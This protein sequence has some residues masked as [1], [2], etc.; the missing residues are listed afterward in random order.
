MYLFIHTLLL[1]FFSAYIS[2]ASFLLL[3]I[4]I[5]LYDCARINVYFILIL[6]AEDAYLLLVSKEST[7]YVDIIT[8]G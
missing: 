8:N 4:I 5:V 3:T 6:E 7:V 1:L 2:F